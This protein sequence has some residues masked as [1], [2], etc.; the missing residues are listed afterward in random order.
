MLYPPVAAEFPAVPWEQKENGF[1][2][3]GRVV[4]E[5]RMD[6]A[7]RILE[8]VREAGHDVHLHI[9]G[10]LDDSPFGVTLLRMALQRRW[11]RLEG[12]TFGQEKS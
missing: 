9:L 7:V 12:R 3:V 2:C 5:K 8:K 4:P 10:S 6:A 11:I 1:V